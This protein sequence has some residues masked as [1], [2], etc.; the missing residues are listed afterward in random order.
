MEKLIYCNDLCLPA[1][2]A[3]T[4][5]S[6]KWD[7]FVISEVRGIG[8]PKFDKKLFDFDFNEVVPLDSFNGKS[9][10]C[11]NRNKRWGLLE[12]KDNQQAHSEW[13]IVVDFLYDDI[14]SML[15]EM[16][17]DSN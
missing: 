6:K 13:S 1:M 11:L 10:V 9:Y 2:V 8:Y 7:L 17:I 5:K 15:S 16:K 14:N 3:R 4:N 12:V